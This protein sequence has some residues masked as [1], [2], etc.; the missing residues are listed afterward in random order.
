MSETCEQCG[1]HMVI[2]SGRYGK[3]LACSGYPQCKNTKPLLIKIGVKCPKCGGD[4]V[5]KK[6]KKKRIF[7]G[8]A[9]YP[10]CNF[11]TSNK[12]L[13]QPCP[14]CGDVLVVRG[15]GTKC[16]KCEFSTSLTKLEQEQ[17]REREVLKV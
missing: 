2:K 17:E 10:G 6:S 11:A 8:C 7:Y 1:G 4:I 12:P 5:E 16:L 13:A 3:F 15:K 14:Q 9:N